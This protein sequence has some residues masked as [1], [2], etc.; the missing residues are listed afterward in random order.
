MPPSSFLPHLRGVRLHSVTITDDQ[1]TV[2]V[3]TVRQTAR[4]PLCQRR[5]KRVHSRYRRTIADLPWNGWCVSIEACVRRFWCRRP[6]CPRR[7]FCE[8]LPPLVPPYG[9]RTLHLGETLT[10]LGYALGGRPGERLAP[11]FGVMASRMTL[12]RLVRAA[13]EMQLPT[14]R[15]LGVD[16]WAQRKRRSYGTILIDVERGW[17][18]DLLPD[19]STDTLA[20]WL[21]EHPGVEIITRDRAGAYADGASRGAPH[22]RQ[23]ADRWHLL[24]NL[25]EAIER[26]LRDRDRLLQQAAQVP[27]PESGSPG[28]DRAGERGLDGAGDDDTSDQAM[29]PLSRAARDR[30]QRRERRNRRYARVRELYKQGIGLREVARTTGISRQTVRRFVRAGSFPEIE[31]R[32]KRPSILDAYEDT[33]LRR[34]NEGC[35]NGHQ[36]YREIEQAGYRGGRTIVA[37][38]VTALRKACGIPPRKRILAGSAPAAAPPL[39]IISSRW[40]SWLVLRVPG[41]RT[42]E[43]QQYVDRL[44]AQDDA[45]ALLI[46]LAQDFAAMLRE[47]GGEKLAAWVDVAEASSM[48]ELQSFAAGLRHDWI[49]VQAGL[50]ETWSNGPTEGHVNR[51]KTIK[52]QMYGRAKFD[53]LRKRVLYRTQARASAS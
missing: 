44:T 26:S 12:L 3:A 33:L 18:V 9:R 25:G 5:S 7:I 42:A 51:L 31:H 46:T 41:E 37:R 29:K 14:P 17:P 35:H 16:D 28:A 2:T 50:T 13:P 48:R 6:R 27:E 30:E 36:L 47:R 43:E 34:W 52:R 20:S 11:A 19:R 45:L 24:K 49:A 32:A 53:L 21:Q 39:R 23:I 4:C 1:I 8:R 38:Y 22:A 15:I 10:A 40:A